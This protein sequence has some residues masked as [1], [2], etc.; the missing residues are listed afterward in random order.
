MFGFDS[1]WA[2]ALK[3]GANQQEGSEKTEGLHRRNKINLTHPRAS[4]Y[5]SKN[6]RSQRRASNTLRRVRF[7]PYE[8]RLFKTPFSTNFSEGSRRV[9][10]PYLD[11]ASRPSPS[12]TL[13]EPQAFRRRRKFLRHVYFRVF[14]GFRQA[15]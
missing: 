2:A 3:A 4:A 13:G 7:P 9:P 6:V 15:I 5:L 10:V 14:P 1:D 12:P 8:P 11:A